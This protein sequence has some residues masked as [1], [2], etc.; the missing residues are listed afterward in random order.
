MSEQAVT[1]SMSHAEAERLTERLRIAVVNYADARQKVQDLIE[2][3]Q[4]GRAWEVLGFQSWTAYVSEV[5]G[6]QPMRLPRGERREMVAMLSATGMSTRAIAPVVGA[7]Q[8]TVSRDLVAGDANASPER[9]TAPPA[10]A[11][12][13]TPVQGMDGKTYARPVRAPKAPNYPGEYR[14]AVISLNNAVRR[15]LHIHEDKRMARNAQKVATVNRSDLLR[16]IDALQR[17]VADLDLAD[18]GDE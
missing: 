11:E 16:A 12:T 17:A 1:V 18:A 13:P 8:A 5:L 9:G 10:V 15:L 14:D 2:R 7:N 6:E 3:A 4:A